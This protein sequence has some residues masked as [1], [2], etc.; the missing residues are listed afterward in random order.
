M[1]YSQH[2]DEEEAILQ[3][4][5]SHVGRALDIGAWVAT[6]FSNTRALYERGW[7]LVLVEPSPGPFII[8]MRT[9]S[10]CGTARTDLW[11]PNKNDKPCGCEHS[12]NERFE[13]Y[14]E[15]PRV[16]LV[17][18]A[19]SPSPDILMFYASDDAVSTSDRKMYTSWGPSG[20]YYG[21]F[22]TPTV[23]VE[24]LWDKFGPFDFLSIDTEGMNQEVLFS[25]PLDRMRPCA[26]CV[27]YSS[28]GERQADVEHMRTH[29]YKEVFHSTG[30]LLF[31]RS[32]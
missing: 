10:H 29:G 3:L 13:S 7:E 19:V 25:I 4:F 24:Q 23:T 28:G 18:A 14:G 22:H 6:T 5:G 26:V 30:N 21:R 27:E 15:D 1:S 20:G 16:K 9:C 17:S 8:L 2:P 31:R 11:V 12:S 32:D